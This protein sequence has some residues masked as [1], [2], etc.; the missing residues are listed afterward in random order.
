M[1][2]DLI[3][4]VTDAVQT[5]PACRRI[6]NIYYEEKQKEQLLQGS[7]SPVL[8]YTLPNLVFDIS[9]DQIIDEVTEFFRYAMKR[10]EWIT[11][12]EAYESHR[13]ERRYRTLKRS[14]E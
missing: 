13:A 14:R 10:G 1:P 11:F 3:D 7:A 2:R 8:L 6:Y 9:R 5:A 12:V 4:M